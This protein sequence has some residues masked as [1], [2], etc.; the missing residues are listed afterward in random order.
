[1]DRAEADERRRLRARRSELR[2]RIDAD[3]LAL[4]ARQLLAQTYRD[5]GYDDQAGRWGVLVPGWTTARERRLFVAV[6][7]RTGASTEE[8]LRRLLALP[9]ESPLDLGDLGELIADFEAEQAEVERP[10]PDLDGWRWIANTRRILCGIALVH[11]VAAIQMLLSE[12]PMEEFLVAARLLLV[13]VAA[14]LVLSAAF[15][16]AVVV[17]QQRRRRREK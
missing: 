15:F 14:L 16:T 10:H 13:G 5:E 11:A 4:E 8:R 17:R 9:P 2:S 6:M 7:E 1:M 12:A 3:P